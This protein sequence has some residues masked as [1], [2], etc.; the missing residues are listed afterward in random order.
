MVLLEAGSSSALHKAVRRG[1]LNM[2][3]CVCMCVYT[4]KSV[5]M[6]M[7]VCIHERVCLCMCAH[8]HM[9]GSVCMCICLCVPVCAHLRVCVHIPVCM[10]MWMCN[11][12]VCMHVCVSLGVLLVLLLWQN[13]ERNNW[14]RVYFGS[15]FP[16]V[17]HHVQES[18][19]QAFE[20][21]GH[22]VSVQSEEAERGKCSCMA[23]FLLFIQPKTWC[24]PY[25]GWSSHCY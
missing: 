20:A 11:M 23:H 12:H 17:V 3:V 6:C 4:F 19:W 8:L 7:Y 18:R 21:A 25:S 5:Y 10:W 24:C 14:G 22:I 13:T 1:L 16:N 15:H 9:C 2:H